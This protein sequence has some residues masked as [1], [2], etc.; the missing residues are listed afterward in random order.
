MKP[1]QIIRFVLELLGLGLIDEFGAAV[2]RR[3]EEIAELPEL[4]VAVF[5]TMVGG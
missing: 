1:V 5:K 3:L 4:A 2:W